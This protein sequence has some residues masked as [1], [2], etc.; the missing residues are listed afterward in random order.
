MSAR[1]PAAAGGGVE[2]GGIIALTTSPSTA[3][4][5]CGPPAPGP[6]IVISVIASDSTVTALNGPR[7]RRADGRDR[8]TPGGREPTGFVADLLGR[9]DQ[10]QPEPEVARVLQ[11]V[12]LDL[13]DSLVTDLVDVDRRVERQP[14]QD[15]HLRRRVVAVDVLG[16]V[17]LGVAEPLCLGE[18]RGER[19]PG[20]RHLGEDEVGRAVDDP[21]DAVDARAGQRLLKDADHGHDAG[22][23]PLEAQLHAALAGQRPELLAVMREQLLVGGDDVF[24]V[25]HRPDHIFARR[26][27]PTDQLDDQIGALQDLLKRPAATREEAGESGAQSGDPLDPVGLR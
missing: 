19:H 10:L 8:G 21:V 4:A 14:G 18:R 13:L 16:R 26:L 7:P 25:L 20:P 2:A 23:R 9:A 5:V 24:A 11:V 22:D 3:L 12:G 27:D 6:D 17:R 15:R 1:S